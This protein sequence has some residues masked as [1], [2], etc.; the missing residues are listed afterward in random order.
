MK[1]R[2]LFFKAQCLWA[3]QRFPGIATPYDTSARS[4]TRSPDR[5]IGE[6]RHDHL[7]IDAA[8]AVLQRRQPKKKRPQPTQQ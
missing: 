5:A 7:R 3:Y 4:S 1:L 8:F 2:K 6:I